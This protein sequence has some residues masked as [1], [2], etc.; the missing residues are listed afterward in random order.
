MSFHQKIG[1]G[2]LFVYIIHTKMRVDEKK[3]RAKIVKNFEVLVAIA[4]A[5]AM[6]KKFAKKNFHRH[7]DRDRD[8]DRDL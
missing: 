2:E 8:Q 5:M 6:K 1:G 4:I 7:H 3:R